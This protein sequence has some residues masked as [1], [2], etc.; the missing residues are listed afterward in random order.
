[1]QRKAFVTGG[2]GFI[3]IN[4]IEMLVNK[5]WNVTALYR[6]TS[7]LQY[8]SKVPVSLKEGTVINKESLQQALPEHT[9][10]VFHLASDTNLWSRNNEMQTRTNVAGTRNLLEVSSAKNVKTFIYTSTAATWGEMNNK[11]ITEELPQK[12]MDSWVNYER[13]KWAAEQEVLNFSGNDMKVVILN[14]TTVTGPYDLNNW[15]RILIALNHKKLPGVPKGMLSINHVHEV[16]NAHIAAVDTGKDANRYLLSG[17]DCT[18]SRFIS[19]IAH[20]SGIKKLPKTIPDF[21][22]KVL[23]HIKSSTAYITG[24]E[25]DITPEL[26]KIMTRKNLAYSCKK[27]VTELDYKITPIEKS[28]RDCYNWLDR[29]GYL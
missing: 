13:T 20:A 18:F 29:E 27:A 8:L 4:L 28:V 19:E 15:G 14:P 3:G 25:P 16:V 7:D 26:V 6:P 11:C 17:K 24:V 5:K 23:A 12:G 1:M 10:T 2:T 22:L 9:D 21:S